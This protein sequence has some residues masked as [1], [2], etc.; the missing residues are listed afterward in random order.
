[1]R[2]F[3]GCS[4]ATAA[5]IGTVRRCRVSELAKTVTYEEAQ[6]I[7]DMK[8]TEL[9][10]IPPQ[11]LTATQWAKLFAR[12][13]VPF[14][15]FGIC[16]NMIMISVGDLIDAEFGI[17][18][19]FSTM[20][21][22]GLGQ[23]VSDGSGVTI[24]QTIQTQ[25]DRRSFCDPNLSVQQG[26]DKFVIFMQQVFRTV[27]IILGCLVALIPVI[28]F[29]T[30]NKARLYDLMLKALPEE[31]RRELIAKGKY[32]T[33]DPGTQLIT[34]GLPVEACYTI[35]SGEVRI[36]GRSNDGD[37]IEL[38]VQGPGNCLGVLELVF[39]HNSVADV[40]TVGKAKLLKIDREDFEAVIGNSPMVRS[41]VDD[42]IA[43]DTEYVAYRIRFPRRSVPSTSAK[44]TSE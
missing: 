18:L 38:C 31:R 17:T 14:F 29:D 11:P 27:G 41:A 43:N 5:V 15:A 34:H 32:V 12:T 10:R 4:F 7:L 39:G 42:Y 36:V 22:A 24:Q 2:R 1:M 37:P 21:A 44:N 40:V 6:R 13:A 19:G 35:L 28:L 20:I 9:L 16:D 25:V 3:P 8:R 23:A 30:G 33:V 26:N